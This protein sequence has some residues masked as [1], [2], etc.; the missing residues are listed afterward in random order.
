MFQGQRPEEAEGFR[1]QAEKLG[2]LI[3]DTMFDD[4]TGFF[5]DVN[6]ETKEPTE[7]EVDAAFE[8]HERQ[9]GEDDE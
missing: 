1:T 5:Y 7:T 4:E 8:K 2:Q 6:L 3:R 9:P